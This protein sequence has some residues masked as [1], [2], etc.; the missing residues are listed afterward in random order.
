MVTTS[1]AR[2]WEAVLHQ[3]VG[4]SDTFRSEFLE[5]GGRKSPIVARLDALRRIETSWLGELVAL[6]N[7]STHRSG[8]PLTFYVGGE[9]DGKVAFKHPH[10]LVEFPE[11]ATDTLTGWLQS[12]R[13]CFDELRESALTIQPNKSSPEGAGS[14]GRL[15]PF[16][17]SRAR[18]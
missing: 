16:G 6:R 4:A 3:L 11:R 13:A 9:S 1:N 14:R 10:T 8:V 12:M 2:I 15:N 18:P 5:L 7:S 17:P